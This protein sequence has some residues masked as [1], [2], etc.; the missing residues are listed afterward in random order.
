MVS[1]T[2]SQV[3]VVMG[4]KAGLWQYKWKQATGKNQGP[5]A[6]TRA[7]CV[8]QRPILRRDL[9]PG[10][11]THGCFTTFKVPTSEGKAF[12]QEPAR[13]IS[14]PNPSKLTSRVS[15]V[16]LVWGVELNKGFPQLLCKSNSFLNV[17]LTSK[18]IG[19][20]A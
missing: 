17:N 13:D 12:K 9:L 2:V 10:A 4:G 6:E 7:W 14:D 1:L 11:L 19:K 20:S 8:L 5:Q 15:L 3:L 18:L 16:F